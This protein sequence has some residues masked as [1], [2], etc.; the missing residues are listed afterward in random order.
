MHDCEKWLGRPIFRRIRSR[1]QIE[2]CG[3]WGGRSN[4]EFF[5]AG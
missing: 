5:P 3:I 2:A 1:H 4:G